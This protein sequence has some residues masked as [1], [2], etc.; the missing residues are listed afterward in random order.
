M[1]LLYGDIGQL[2]AQLIDMAVV[3]VWGFGSGFILFW[4]LKK[5]IG[6]RAS[7]E[8]E[9]AGLDVPEHGIEAYP[10]TNGPVPASAKR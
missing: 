9:M 2:I 7:R 10:E 8:E 4:L 5:T 3:S 1:G 6:L